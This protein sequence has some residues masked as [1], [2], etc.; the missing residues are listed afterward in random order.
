MPVVL[1]VG[2]PDVLSPLPVVL[3]VGPPVV[4]PLVPKR[5]ERRR[6][7]WYYRHDRHRHPRYYRDDTRGSTGMTTRRYPWY[8]CGVLPSLPVILA[9]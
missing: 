5:H 3:P 8:H 2:P 1:P 6:D 7:P 4:L 9:A